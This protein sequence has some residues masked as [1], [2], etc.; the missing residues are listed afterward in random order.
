MQTMISLINTGGGIHRP[1]LDLSDHPVFQAL[2]LG[3][4]STA[5]AHSSLASIPA[6][7]PLVEKGFL[8]FVLAGVL[9]LFPHG[10]RICVATIVAGSVHGWDQ[11]LDPTGDQPEARALID[12]TLCRIPAACLVES[13]GRD[14]L[15]RLVARQSSGR[16]SNLAAEAA[17]NAS[18]LVQERLAKWLVRLY[19]GANGAPLRLTQADFGGMLGV[20]RTSVNA[21]A[22]RLQEK[23]LVRFGRGKVQILDLAGLRAASCGCGDHKVRPAG[24]ESRDTQL[25][26]TAA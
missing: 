23:G 26:D 5:Q 25:Q 22:G 20:Q 2:P 19:C 9:G 17:C 3:V 11:A 10:D 21:A 18:H 15:T 12:T 24:D 16:L 4:Q 7:E 1:R 14:W 13:L 8:S 6:G